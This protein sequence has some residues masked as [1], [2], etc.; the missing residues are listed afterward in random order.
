MS[1]R[2]KTLY[3]ALVGAWGG[4]LAWL[5][6]D[7]LIERLFG[8]RLTNV[9]LDAS[10]N[11]AIVGMCIGALVSGFGG[12]AAARFLLLA[13]G[14][15]VGLFTGVLGGVLGL[16]AG[17]AAFQLGG[18]LSAEVLV[19]GMF[20]ALGWAIFGAGIG[21][22]EGVMTLSPKRFLF[23]G[24]GGV[25]GGFA[26]G[27]LF[28]LIERVLNL[29]LFNRALGFAI[30]GACIGLFVGLIPDLL[31]EAWLKVVS[32]GRNEG[33]E[34]LLDKQVNTIGSAERR[35]VAL[36]G[37]NAIAPKH[38]EIRQESGQF[39]L[40]ALAGQRVEVDDRPAT[41]VALQDGARVRIGA[42]KM[43]FRRR[44]S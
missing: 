32:S 19:R 26:G 24:L 8:V 30:L 43:V 10:L 21:V 25:I 27:I 15:I 16:L 23:G 40:H 29:Q 4:L 13:R 6:L 5:L 22:A 31:K 14:L 1:L 3:N 44:K 9:W 17:Q 39:V 38:A 28:A 11:G 42:T 2:L 35:D 12:L 34:F 37:D 18:I 41:R 20:R 36:F 33:S 7:L